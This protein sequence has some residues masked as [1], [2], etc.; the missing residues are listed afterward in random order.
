[1]ENWGT[2]GCRIESPKRGK[3]ETAVG[4]TVFQEKWIGDETFVGVGR[5]LSGVYVRTSL[6]S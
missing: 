1:M 2:E 5:S 4:I 6:C 3:L